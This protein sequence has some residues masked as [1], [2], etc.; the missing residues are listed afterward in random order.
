MNRKNFA[1]QA[2]ATAFFFVIVQ[3]AAF[4]QEKPWPNTT[5]VGAAQGYNPKLTDDFYAAVNREWLSSAKIPQGYPRT[6]SFTERAIQVD[7]ELLSLMTRK[8]VKGRAAQRR[9]MAKYHV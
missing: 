9:H 7:K 4:S 6:G 1:L 8:D 2:L 5:V 3:T